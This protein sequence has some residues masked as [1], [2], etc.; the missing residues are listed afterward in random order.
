[1]KK[2]VCVFACISLLL[3][4]MNDNVFSSSF[5]YH[6]IKNTA[7]EAYGKLD[8]SYNYGRH[9]FEF[10]K[11]DKIVHY[12]NGEYKDV[13]MW[14]SDYK[15]DNIKVVKESSPFG[16]NYSFEIVDRYSIKLDGLSLKR[17]YH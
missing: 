5:H 14:K 3:F 2:S 17:V 6:W 13:Y 12:I 8:N 15:G 9:R 4:C 10:D 7:W 1:M 11:S 16:K